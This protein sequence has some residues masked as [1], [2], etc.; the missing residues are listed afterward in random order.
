MK[1]LKVVFIVIFSLCFASCEDFFLSEVDAPVLNTK[2][3]LVVHSYISPNSGIVVSVKRSEPVFSKQKPSWADKEQIKDATVVLT[4]LATKQSL[5]IA[6]NTEQRKYFSMAEAFKIEAGQSYSL[7]VSTPNGESVSATCTVPNVISSEIK[8]IKVQKSEFSEKEIVFEVNDNPTEENF[9]IAQATA[10]NDENS[11]I[12][13]RNYIFSDKN[14]NGKNIV[15]KPKNT[16]YS[17]QDAPIAKIKITLFSVDKSYYDYAKSINSQMDN[18]DNPFSDP[19]V[20]VSN[21]QGGL[22]VFGAYTTLTK[23]VEI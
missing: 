21:I 11:V 6:F 19:S 4:N 20:I 10:Y 13:Q 22:G 1:T 5:Q 23:T 16:S 18:D 3:Q 7:Q 8:N 17:Y 15:A 9:Y 12:Q 2:P 14:K